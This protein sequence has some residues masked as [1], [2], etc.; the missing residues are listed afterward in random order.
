MSLP[1][2]NQILLATL[3]RK[4]LSWE[5]AIKVPSYC[6][7]AWIRMLTDC[8]SRWL[9]GS[10]RIRKLESVVRDLARATLDFSPP[11]STLIFL[12]TSSPVNRKQPRIPRSSVSVCLGAKACS[13]SK[14][15]LSRCSDSS[16]CW[17]KKVVV[18]LWPVS[19]LPVNFSVPAMILSK[20]DLPLPFAPIS[21]ILSPF[22][23]IPSAFSRISTLG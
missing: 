13:S 12:K 6:C 14:M 23:I 3:S 4:Y 8:M 21:A 9:V 11:E 7:K 18:T 19:H 10:S 22:S 5:T 2:M 20:V 16:W 15:V 1:S 17:A